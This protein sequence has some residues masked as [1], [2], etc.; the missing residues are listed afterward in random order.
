MRA[1]GDVDLGRRD[2][3]C[4]CCSVVDDVALSALLDRLEAARASV[5]RYEHGISWDTTCENCAHMLDRS[6]AETVR[7]EAAEAAL[8]R[9]EALAGWFEHQHN[10]REWRIHNQIRAALSPTGGTE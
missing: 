7:A 3:S 5:A 8:A 6:Y 10:W 4:G 2:A 1:V 9:V